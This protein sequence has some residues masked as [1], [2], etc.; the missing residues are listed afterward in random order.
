MARWRHSF[1][2]LVPSWLSTGDGEKVLH[3]LGRVTDWFVERARQA[4][5]ARFPTYSAPTGLQML[6]AERGLPRGKNENNVGYARRLHGWR[7]EHGHQVRGSAYAMLRQIWQYFGG[8]KAQ[9][10]DAGG[11]VFT[12]A[13]DGAESATHGGF[14]NWD[15]PPPPVPGF[16]VAGID[17]TPDAAEHDATAGSDFGTPEGAGT[18]AVEVAAS[19]AGTLTLHCDGTPGRLIFLN[20]VGNNTE[21]TAVPRGEGWVLVATNVAPTG[22][23][24][25]YTHHVY[26]KIC[27]PYDTFTNVVVDCVNGDTVDGAHFIGRAV[28]V[29]GVF[30]GDPVLEVVI[31][32]GDGTVVI[33]PELAG[34]TFNTLALA[35]IAGRATTYTEMAGWAELGAERTDGAPG[36]AVCEQIALNAAGV[37]VA[38]VAVVLG[39]TSAVSLIFV[40]V[41]HKVEQDWFRFWLKLVPESDQGIHSWG[42]W[43]EDAVR[44]TGTWGDGADETWGQ[45]GVTPGDA[46]VVSELFRG[47]HPWHMA[48][49]KPE[50]LIVVL[51]Q[52][53]AHEPDGTWADWI[54]EGEPTRYE[55]WRYWKI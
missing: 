24:G 17:P 18:G 55:G 21:T 46:A 20:L 27:G 3:T 36:V 19:G 40:S 14:W 2:K 26:R 34:Q 12:V 33:T 23:G 39:A 16:P 41:Q 9:E 43:G 50:W 28:N 54:Y 5:T 1:Y 52:D 25:P 38:P 30:T 32:D 45:T 7:G 53:E 15:A 42:T 8:I 6:G 22:T 48:G 13:R 4:Y 49:T 44:G 31:A 29:P 10:I 37:G 35:F 11:N 47:D 51:G